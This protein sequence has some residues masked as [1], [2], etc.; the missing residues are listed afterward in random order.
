MRFLGRNSRRNNTAKESQFPATPSVQRYHP[1]TISNCTV[2]YWG[3]SEIHLHRVPCP[4]TSSSVYVYVIVQDNPPWDGAMLSFSSSSFSS[5]YLMQFS[6]GKCLFQMRH[7]P[8]TNTCN[9]PSR[10]H[11]APGN[12]RTSRMRIQTTYIEQGIAC[13]LKSLYHPN[14]E[15][16]LLFLNGKY[17]CKRRFCWWQS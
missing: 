15:T 5:S 13:I 6:P 17:C 3:L 4:P 10:I 14:K 1:P 8:Q 7:V 2:F 12:R 11:Q 16:Y 9:R